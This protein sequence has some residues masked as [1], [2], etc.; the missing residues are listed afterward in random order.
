MDWQSLRISGRGSLSCTCGLVPGGFPGDVSAQ[1][2]PF[3]PPIQQVLVSSCL[4]H[5]EV[6]TA[7]MCLSG[8]GYH[9]A[10]GKER[11]TNLYWYP[12]GTVSP[13]QSGEVA[14]IIPFLHRRDLGLKEASFIHL[15]NRYSLN[16]FCAKFW[17]Q[18]KVT[19]LLSGWGGF[20]RLRMGSGFK[21]LILPHPIWC[22]KKVRD[23]ILRV[24]TKWLGCQY[25]RTR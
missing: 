20:G 13:Q 19:E 9:R 10:L 18:H 8:G 11:G 14:T 3:L 22:L 24:T 21:P 4:A 5:L 15:F 25:I 7:W 17:V 23:F 16:T 2:M 6:C 12:P 1:L